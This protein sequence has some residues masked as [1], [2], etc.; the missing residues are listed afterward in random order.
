VGNAAAYAAFLQGLG[1]EIIL[2]D[3]DR[4]RAEGEAMDLMHGQ[5]FVKFIHKVFHHLISGIP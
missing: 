5:A 1:S 4:R 3:K 2:I